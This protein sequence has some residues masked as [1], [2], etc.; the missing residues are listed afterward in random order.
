VIGMKLGLF[1]AVAVLLAPG[2]SSAGQERA[3]PRQAYITDDPARPD[4]LGLATQDG[5][6]MLQLGEGCNGVRSGVN[7]L[8][9]ADDVGALTLQVIDPV[10][11]LLDE[12]CEVV[13]LQHTSDVPCRMNAD[14]L[15]D[16]VSG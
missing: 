14:G 16:V 7:V 5:R 10:L 15:C 4:R 3:S 12:E 11:G 8:V 6:Y 9:A 1:L 13:D 2:A